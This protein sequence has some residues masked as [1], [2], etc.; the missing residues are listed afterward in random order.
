MIPNLL[1]IGAS[2][3]TGS[4]GVQADLKTFGARG[5][6]GMA[7]ITAL[8]AQNTQCN[9]GLDPVAPDFVAAQLAAV[10]ADV[11]L[12]AIKIGMVP[13]AP[14][15]HRIVEALPPDVPLVLDPEMISPTGAHLLPDEAMQA[16]MNDL[17]PRAA[18]L[19]ANI[20]EAAVLLHIDPAANTQE[21]AAQALRLAEMGPGCV[22]LTGGRLGQPSCAD[23]MASAE[24]LRWFEAPRIDADTT[25]GSGCTLSAALAAEIARGAL[26]GDAAEAAKSY[27]TGCIR[28]GGRLRVGAGSGP[29]N[30]FYA[31]FTDVEA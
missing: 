9:G 5:V 31:H 17:I 26:P 18:V 7:V 24:G 6:Y 14:A 3:P 12:D 19:V 2:D 21:M 13:S 25:R 10:A 1:T 29:V 23:V 4:T 16:L 27:L 11:R 8:T 30:H 28:A 20:D 22:L 15:V